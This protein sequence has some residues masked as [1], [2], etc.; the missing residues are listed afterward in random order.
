[1]SI[2]KD[3][4]IAEIKEKAQVSQEYYDKIRT[5]KTNA[6]ANHYKKK[7]AEHNNVLADLIISLDK[8]NNSDYNSQ[9]TSNNDKNG[10]NIDDEHERNRES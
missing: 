3:A 7:L 5:A 10:N 6:K 1:M 2:V 8:L 9:D 4:L